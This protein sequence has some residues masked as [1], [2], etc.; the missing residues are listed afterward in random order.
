MDNGGKKTQTMVQ[1]VLGI[2][3]TE[4][5]DIQYKNTQHRMLFSTLNKIDS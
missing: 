1:R 5:N 3:T 2:T 4:H